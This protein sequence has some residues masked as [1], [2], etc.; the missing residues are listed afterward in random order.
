[1]RIVCPPSFIYETLIKKVRKIKHFLPYEYQVF[2]VIVKVLAYF[3][4]METEFIY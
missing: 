4:F 2:K 1:M 3:T